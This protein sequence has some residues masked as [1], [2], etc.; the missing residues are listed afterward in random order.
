M[1]NNSSSSSSRVMNRRSIENRRSQ[2]NDKGLERKDSGH[3][4]GFEW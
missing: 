3:N 2:S 4:I 1:K